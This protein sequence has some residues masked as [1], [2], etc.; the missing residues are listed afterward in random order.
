MKEW[1]EYSTTT[2]GVDV[3]GGVLAVQSVADK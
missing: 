1:K 3:V 2:N